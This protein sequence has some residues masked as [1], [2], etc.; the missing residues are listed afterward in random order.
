MA[1]ASRAAIDRLKLLYK[2]QGPGR[3][4]KFMVKCE[5]VL[6][7]AIQELDARNT[8]NFPLGLEQVRI[9]RIDG[10]DWYKNVSDWTLDIALGYLKRME[11][12]EA[13][14]NAKDAR[15]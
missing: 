1:V 6:W 3:S 11:N 12:L 8:S 13:I 14:M 5:S 9:V 7:V 4:G 15:K 10:D 2:P